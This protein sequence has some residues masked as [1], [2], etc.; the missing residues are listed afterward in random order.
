MKH[1]SQL[2]QEERYFFSI[3]KARGV[4]IPKIAK[5]LD[6]APSTLYRE[7]K[8]NIRPTTGYYQ[9][10][11]A[12]SYTTA[13]RRRS[14]K[15]SHFPKECWNLIIKLL[16]QQWSPEQISAYLKRKKLFSISFQTIYRWIRKD[17]RH[18][19]TLFKFLR[20]MPKRRRKRYGSD[21]SRGTLRGKRSIS[22]RLAIINERLL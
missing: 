21:D 6:R 16:A 3:L 4:P 7:L 19:G 15:G 11:I 13:R 14:R 22:E 1:Y 18:G 10:Y 17:R 2:S 8:R 9:A 12:D 5:E 20:I